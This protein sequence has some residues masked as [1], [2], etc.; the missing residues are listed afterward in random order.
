MAQE[1]TKN[2]D[3]T[4]D[5]DAKITKIEEEFV[6][7]FIFPMMRAEAYDMKIG[8]IQTLTS[9]QKE[10]L[11]KCGFSRLYPEQSARGCHDRKS[12]YEW[13]D[14]EENF[15]IEIGMQEYLPH[16]YTVKKFSL[17]TELTII[18]PISISL[19]EDFQKRLINFLD[20]YSSE[21]NTLSFRKPISKEFSSCVGD[22]DFPKGTYQGF[23]CSSITLGSS[24]ISHDPF[25]FMFIDRKQKLASFYNFQGLKQQLEKG[26][27]NRFLTRFCTHIKGSGYSSEDMPQRYTSNPKI[28]LKGMIATVFDIDGNE[29]DR[30]EI[31][32]HQASDLWAGATKGTRE[33]RTAGMVSGVGRSNS[34]VLVQDN[35][36]NTSILTDHNGA[37][38]T[39]GHLITDDYLI[40]PGSQTGCRTGGWAAEMPAF[41]LVSNYEYN[42]LMQ[43]DRKSIEKISSISI[44][45]IP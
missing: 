23:N 19:K 32:L 29:I 30:V 35:G 41:N 43:I 38:T 3:L 1:V 21:K 15:D 20:Q 33:Y 16:S 24:T 4:L 9:Y 28:Q 8:D 31:N 44:N 14:N 5:S 13:F 37:P 7:E 17:N 34:F 25:V 6:N 18:V 26:R 22:N 40:Y 11:I 39:V 42:L 27:K 12:Y 2:I 36:S 45:Y 10:N